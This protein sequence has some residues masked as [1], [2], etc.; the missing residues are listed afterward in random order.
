VFS[1]AG[2]RPPGLQEAVQGLF[3]GSP[4][5]INDAKTRVEPI[6]GRIKVH[7]LLVHAHQI[8]L[9]KG[10]RNR[11]RAYRHIL[12]TR[13]DPANARVLRGHVEYA[14]HVA[15]LAIDS[16]VCHPADA[17]RLTLQIPKREVPAVID[18]ERVPA[19]TEQRQSIWSAVRNLFR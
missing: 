19:A 10:Y 5:T 8:R 9:T 11:I 14:K 12:E 2:E 16:G 17:A 18:H 13:D 7:G 1:G 15:D 3:A 4:W 6:K